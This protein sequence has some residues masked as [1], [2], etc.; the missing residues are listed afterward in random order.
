[1]KEAYGKQTLA[2]SVIFHWHQQF[3]EEWASASPKPNSGRLVVSSTETTVNM[4]GTMLADDD[5]LSQ[6]QIALVGI[7]QTTLKKIILSF[8]SWN[9]CSA[10]RLCFYAKCSYGRSICVIL[11]WFSHRW[12]NKLRATGCF[13]YFFDSQ[14]SRLVMGLVLLLKTQSLYITWM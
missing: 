7:F 5:S 2:R 13:S 6:R 11:G 9:F 14:H 3:T 4:I 1:M 12:R 8:L 10:V